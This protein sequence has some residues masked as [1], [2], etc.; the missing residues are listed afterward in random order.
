MKSFVVMVETQDWRGYSRS[1]E[2][3]REVDFESIS[4]LREMYSEERSEAEVTFQSRDWDWKDTSS[5]VSYWYQG[6]LR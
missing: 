4:L 6:S 5:E 2:V 3:C 1:Y